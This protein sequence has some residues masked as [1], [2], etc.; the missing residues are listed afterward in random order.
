MRDELRKAAGLIPNTHT[1][2]PAGLKA[3]RLWLRSL[4]SQADSGHVRKLLRSLLLLCLFL[5]ADVID[6][7]L[8]AGYNM[9][10]LLYQGLAG[11]AILSFR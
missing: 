3:P 2:C 6:C 10:K 9:K 5:T 4:S 7:W 1:A 8:L 11:S